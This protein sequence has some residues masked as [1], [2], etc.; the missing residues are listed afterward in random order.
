MNAILEFNPD[1][2]SERTVRLILAKATEWQCTPL[3]AV[4]RLMDELAERDLKRN[5]KQAA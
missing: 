5:P 3:E 2:Y 1:N 4:S